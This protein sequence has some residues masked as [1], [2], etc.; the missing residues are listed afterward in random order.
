MK[1]TILKVL[2]A[3]FITL[4]L[5]PVLC[6]VLF[7][8]YEMFGMVVNHRAT[9]T[10]TKELTA[11]IEENMEDVK[12]V[13]VYSETGNTSG[14][15]NHV[16]CLSQITFTTKSTRKQVVEIMSTKYTNYDIDD[17]KDGFMITL[18]TTAP[19]SDNLE[20]H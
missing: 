13:D 5:L 10:Q 4:L 9:D 16:D 14:T 6:V 2:K 20:G 18:N 8:G 1:K 11:Y 7:I 12:I 19:F 15:G 17:T 3:T